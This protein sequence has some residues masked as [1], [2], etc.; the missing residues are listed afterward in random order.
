MPLTERD[1]NR[2]RLRLKYE[3]G[4]F[5]SWNG[6][7]VYFWYPGHPSSY[8]ATRYQPPGWHIDEDEVEAGDRGLAVAPTHIAIRQLIQ[9]ANP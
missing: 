6:R 1:V 3:I 8:Y 5:E 7:A 2:A 9:S 4:F